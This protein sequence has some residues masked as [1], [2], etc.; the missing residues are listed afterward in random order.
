MLASRIIST[1][2]K[3]QKL[4]KLKN[5]QLALAAGYQTRTVND[6]PTKQRLTM[7]ELIDW[8]NVLGYEVTLVRR[9]KG[10]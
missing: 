9:K 6:W 7:Y 4:L 10:V 1:L 8:A 5:S 3:T 2:V